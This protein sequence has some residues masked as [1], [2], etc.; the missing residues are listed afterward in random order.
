MKTEGKRR[1]VITG[2]GVVSPGGIGQQAFWQTMITGTTRIS[3]LRHLDTLPLY[4]AGTVQDFL[5]DDYIDRKLQ[6]RTDR[7]THFALAAIQEALADA[8]LQFE[9]ENPQRVGAVIANTLGGVNH[10]LQQLESLYTRGPRFVSAYAAIAWLH[11]ANV[12]QA[13]IRY[14]IRGYSKTPVNDTVGGLN[15]LSMAYTAI[16]R[17]VADVIIAGGC[18]AFL[19]P[20]ILL[21][22]AQQGHVFTGTDPQA[23]RPFD[24]RA[25]GFI[26]AEGAGICILEEYEH[27]RKRRARIY[28][29]IIGYGQTHEARGLHPPSQDGK[30]YARAITQA[31]QEGNISPASISYFS[32]DGRASRSA[33]QGEATALHMAL[34]PYAETIP[35]SVPRTMIGH[36]YAAAGALD[37]I[38]SLLTLQHGIIPPTINC[39]E[40]DPGYKLRLICNQ[41]SSLDQ[42]DEQE[43]QASRIALVGGRGIGGTNI[44][45]ALRRGND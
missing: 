45:L 28:G 35:C 32:L 14:G 21:V 37:V 41:A 29:E 12:G 22:L 30:H 23:Y 16:Q 5:V 19:N 10:G 13:A 20:Y 2:L 27:A 9:D 36:S 17:G 24:R 8:Q 7:M 34:G 15:A 44:V 39:S 4:V 26:V 3:P 33:D 25:Q 6:H 31:L 43:E 42:T 38:T 18:E 11:V 40:Y 1:V